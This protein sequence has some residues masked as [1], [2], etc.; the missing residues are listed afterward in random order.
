M[1]IHVILDGITIIEAAATCT[2]RP[3]FIVQCPD[4]CTVLHV[5]SHY[6]LGEVAALRPHHGIS[7]PNV[8]AFRR[9]VGP[10]YHRGLVVAPDDWYGSRTSISSINI[11]L[12]QLVSVRMTIIYTNVIVP[13]FNMIAVSELLNAVSWHER[14]FTTRDSSVRQIVH[15]WLHRFVHDI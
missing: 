15:R 2:A 7:L 11:R 8:Q 9:G 13:G 3:N 5:A 12:G 14:A 6:F 10:S 1:N 4:F